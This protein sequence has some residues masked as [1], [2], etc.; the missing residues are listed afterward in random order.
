MKAESVPLAIAPDHP[1]FA[2]HFPGQPLVPGVVLL[3]LALVAIAGLMRIDL[4][5]CRIAS[6]KFHS[7]ASPGDPVSLRYDIL[8]SGT[9]RFELDSLG[10]KLA[11][12]SFIPQ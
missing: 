8:A 12:G 7:P 4:S 2:G 3:D 5:A 6:A 10:R 9:V 11:S 1:A